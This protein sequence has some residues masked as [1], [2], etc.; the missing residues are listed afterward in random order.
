MMD[1]EG[2]LITL[3]DA[4]GKLIELLNAQLENQPR[5]DSERFFVGDSDM[6]GA[7]TALTVT[8]SVSRQWVTRLVKAY[9]DVRDGFNYTWTIDG[10]PIDVNLAEFY[11]GR[12]ITGESIILRIENPTAVDEFVGYYLYGWGDRVD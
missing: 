3:I 9:C 5:K 12:H 6:V 4:Q 10:R 1:L 11:H 2:K 7:G 8:F